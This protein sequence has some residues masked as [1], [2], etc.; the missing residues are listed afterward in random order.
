MVKKNEFKISL[1]INIPTIFMK[2]GIK[3]SDILSTLISLLSINDVSFDRWKSVGKKETWWR[4]RGVGVGA[5]IMTTVF[6]FYIF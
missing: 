5:K 3:I 1:Y 4:C 2:N 6:L